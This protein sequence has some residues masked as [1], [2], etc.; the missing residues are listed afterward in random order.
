M[1]KNIT[2]LLIEQLPVVNSVDHQANR[3][4]QWRL[5]LCE[6][7]QHFGSS[8]NQRLLILLGGVTELSA[9]NDLDLVASDSHNDLRRL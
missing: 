2:D 3:P 4:G 5:A 1:S 9:E 7:Q 6:A 8:V